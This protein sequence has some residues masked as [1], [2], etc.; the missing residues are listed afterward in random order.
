MPYHG[1]YRNRFFPCMILSSQRKLDPPSTLPTSTVPRHSKHFNHRDKLFAKQK[2]V[3][4]TRDGRQPGASS[5][6][7]TLHD[8]CSQMIGEPIICVY[9]SVLEVDFYR[10]HHGGG[11]GIDVT[12]MSLII[13]ESDRLED[14]TNTS[15]ELTSVTKGSIDPTMVRLESIIFAPQSFSLLKASSTSGEPAVSTD[16]DPHTSVPHITYRQQGV[17][18]LR[19]CV[20]NM[21]DSA[22]VAKISK[23]LH[24]V[25]FF[26]DPISLT[27]ER[28]LGV[29]EQTC[30]IPFDFKAALGR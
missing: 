3:R 13:V 15:G 14:G 7:L 2:K 11:N 21:E 5:D 18:N 6:P 23:I 27:A 22:A 8:Y 4:E 30:P 9:F 25:D 26:V 29:I 12:A 1:P 24:A 16:T 28:N 17:E 10:L 20:V 19:R